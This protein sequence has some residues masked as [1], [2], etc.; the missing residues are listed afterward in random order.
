[1][2]TISRVFSV[3]F[4]GKRVLLLLKKFTTDICLHCVS[5]STNGSEWT[6][7]RTDIVSLPIIQFS[8]IVRQ[9]KSDLPTLF[10]YPP[11]ERSERRDIL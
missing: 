10:L 3:D 2:A 7:L 6:L 1:M 9:K 5:C 4:N 8:T 11:S